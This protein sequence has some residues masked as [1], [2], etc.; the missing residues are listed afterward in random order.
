M[1]YKVLS[2]AMSIVSLGNKSWW[3]YEEPHK[4]IKLNS[5]VIVIF[6][7][8][9]LATQLMYLYVNRS[10]I[11]FD[12]LGVIFSIVPVSALANVNVYSARLGSYKT[13]M[14]DFMSKIHIFNKF[15]Q[16]DEFM[17]KKILTIERVTRWTAYYLIF[18]F[19]INWVAWIWIPVYNNIR[20]KEHI[21]NRTMK[22]QTC[23]YMWFP[24]DYNYNYTNW[25]LIHILNI[26]IVGCGVIV[27]MIFHTLNYIFIFHLIGHIQILKH[28]LRTEL[29]N[30]MSDDVV[31]KN[32]EAAFGINVAANYL[33]NL[34][35]DSLIMYQ[36]M[37]GNRENVILYIVMVC[38]YMGELILMSFVLE[39]IK[40]QCCFFCNLF[41]IEF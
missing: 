4:L 27:M 14:N 25:L 3:G 9:C 30:D 36:I 26:Y 32:V 39:E 31:F 22:L 24:F 37:Y 1:F 19:A 16:N 18:F 7:P 40:R 38:V 28:K 10:V 41:N 33:H 29:T 21:Q 2:L 20:Y 12:T 15:S 6:A 34:L 17:K 23:I 13:I 8:A 11:T 5:L 35:G